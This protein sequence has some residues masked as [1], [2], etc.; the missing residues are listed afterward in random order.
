M[1]DKVTVPVSEIELIDKVNE[2]IDDKQDTLISGTNIKTING[3]DILGSGNIT[4][5]GG[6]TISTP[7][8][9]NIAGTL[10]D[11][12]DLK[13][14]LDAKYDSS[15]PDGYQANVIET[16]KVNG[17]V[18]PVTT[19]TVDITIPTAVSVDGESITYN[20]DNEIQTVAVIDDRT[21]DAHKVWTGTR[22]QYE[23]L[24]EIDDNMIYNITD[25]ENAPGYLNI[26]RTMGQIVTSSIPLVDSGLH[27]LDG[28]LLYET[29]VY[30]AFVDYIAE[31]YNTTPTANYFCTE[32]EWQADVTTYGVCGKFVINAAT[33]SSTV[34]V[35]GNDFHLTGTRRP[36]SDITYNDNVYAAWYVPELS[37]DVYTESANAQIGDT[38]LVYENG[39]FY[40][41]YWGQEYDVESVTVSSIR[42]P[43]I[44][45]FVEGASGVATLGDLTEAGL[46]N[47]TGGY[48]DARSW[49]EYGVTGAFTG[50][51]IVGTGG[52]D[53][54]SSAPNSTIVFNASNSNPIYGNSNTVQPQSVK[55]LY[56]I[57]VANA[58]KTSIEV[59]IDEITTDLNGKADVYFTNINNQAKISIAHNAMPSDTYEDLTLGASGTEYTAPADGYFFVAKQASG[60]NQRLAIFNITT[61][62]TTKVGS[63]IFSNASGNNLMA[64]APVRKDDKVIVN[65]TASGVS[66]FRFIYAQG[67]ESEA[68]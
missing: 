37:G 26:T 48:H 45:G 38:I 5:S 64:Y 49:I 41:T 61:S 20:T 10:S 12:T 35:G 7:T 53:Y 3:I 50:T 8:W 56:Y 17:S 6:G 15:N 66:E 51:A 57:V 40:D 11:Q 67:S 28:A 60:A 46:P 19:K 36:S 54:Y 4:I 21:G 62:S 65:Y 33:I 25:D 14:A 42:L 30:K 23:A 29:G 13:N 34:N 58:I 63:S 16:I 68:S 22:A 52:A 31:L 9:G 44:T 39:Q 43:K 18:Q 27:L 59:D 24:Q 1:V 32:E 55:V 47:I 2:L